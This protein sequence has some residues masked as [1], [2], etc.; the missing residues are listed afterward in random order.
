MDKLEFS[1]KKA[2]LCATCVHS[3]IVKSERGSAFI[4]C[5]RSK[6]DPAF[7]K[8]PPLPVRECVGFEIKLEK[9]EDE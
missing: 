1:N 6:T 4:L 5:L 3:K 7:P 8:Y 9:Q 2:G